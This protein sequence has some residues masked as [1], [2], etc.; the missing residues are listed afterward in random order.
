MQQQS[1]GEGVGTTIEERPGAFSTSP[2]QIIRS[3]VSIPKSASSYPP[4][5][6]GY[7]NMLVRLNGVA[8]FIGIVGLTIA[9]GVLV[10]LLVMYPSESVKN[11][12]YR[13]PSES[14]L[15]HEPPVSFTASVGFSVANICSG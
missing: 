15:S 6:D 4:V 9:A 5:A 13:Y 3:L 10:V 7:G 1:P 14:S 2:S 8:T 11:H 12:F